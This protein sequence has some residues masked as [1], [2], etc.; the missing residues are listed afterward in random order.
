MIDRPISRRTEIILVTAVLLLAAILRMG[1]PGLTEFKADEARL[2]QLAYDM[3]EGQF[4]LRGISSSVGFPNFPMSVW[5]YALPSLLW[6]HPYAATLFT[7]LLNTIAVA[8]CYWFVR[9]YWGVTAAL[10]ATIMLAVSPWAIIFSRKI[11]AQNLLPLFVMGWG[12][13]ATLAFVEQKS[14]YLWLHFLCLALAVQIH[15]A[16]VAL[17]PATAVYLLIF[18]RRIAWKHVGVGIAIGIGTAVPFLIYLWQNGSTTNLL[19]MLRSNQQAAF[20]FDSIRLTAILSLG[21]DIHSLAG[22]E[23]YSAYLAHLPALLRGLV[24]GLWGIFIIGG[25]LYAAYGIGRQRQ[26]PIANRAQ[27]EASLILLIWLCMPPLLFLWHST[28]VFIHY[29]IATLPAQYILAGIFIS[30]IAYSVL[31]KP[32]TVHRLPLTAH[33]SPITAYRLPFTWTILLATAVYHIFAWGTLLNFLGETATPGGFG[34]PLAMQLQAVFQVKDMMDKTGASEVIISG[35][36]ENPAQDEF[37]AIF[38]TL[39]ED[40][41]HRFVDGRRSALFPA[42]TAVVLLQNEDEVQELGRVYGRHALLVGATLLR[43]IEGAYELVAIPGAAAPAPTIPF[44]ETYLFNNWVNPLGYTWQVAGETAVYDLTWRTGDNPDPADYHFFNHLLDDAGQRIAQADAAAFAPWQWHAGDVVVS[45]F[46][47]S[48][49][50]TAVP[51]TLRTGMY[52]YPALDPIMLLDVAGN[53]YA[54]AIQI[55][56]SE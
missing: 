1:W 2:L 19:N 3:A 55:R 38:H 44:T 7:G 24:Y 40:V 5:L 13:S 18:R 25:I 9:R 47:L 35:V 20:S 50:A 16:A 15:L 34:T 32:F 21:T 31:R 12:I 41:P 22:A 49:D 46:W 33:R 48:W 26:S 29:F 43:R 4:A 6:P 17:I 28:P 37:A 56:P 36:G 39:L 51:A 30:R 23:A 8:G 42:H 14:R 54:D 52:N 11:W 27:H 53:P 45:R 10:V